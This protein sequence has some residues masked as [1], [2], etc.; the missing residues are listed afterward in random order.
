MIPQQPNFFR[1]ARADDGRWSLRDPNN[2]PFWMA[3]VNHLHLGP[4][5]QKPDVWARELNDETAWRDFVVAFS[6][7]HGF[8]AL[9][10]DFPTPRPNFP[11][12]WRV[13][14]GT[15]ASAWMD[16]VQFPDVWAP[17][18]ETACQNSARRAANQV[19]DDPFLIG[20]F[21]D[22]CLEW[23]NFGAAKRRA[24]NWIETLQRL[25]PA[26]PAKRA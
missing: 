11:Y 1:V 10:Y 17:A 18:F 2:Q 3:A 4:L 22:D 9:G 6:R 12:V 7:A 26:A 20:Y 5:A 8:N 19:G 23:P 13:E 14:S 25:P 21:L 24:G 16:E 15:R